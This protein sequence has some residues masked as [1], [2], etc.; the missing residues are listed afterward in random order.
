[1]QPRQFGFLAHFIKFA[2]WSIE[3]HAKMSQCQIWFVLWQ[4]MQS[5]LS[6]KTEFLG[7]RKEKLRVAGFK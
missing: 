2:E 1:M 6:F 7:K 4:F 5:G 3:S